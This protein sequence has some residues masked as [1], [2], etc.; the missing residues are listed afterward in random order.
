MITHFLSAIDLFRAQKLRFLL[1]VSGIV[2]GVGSLVL[3][4]SLLTTGAR[5]LEAQS[6][7]ASGDDVVTVQND[8]HRMQND[9]NAQRLRATDKDALDRSALLDG[10]TISANYGMRRGVNAQFKGKEFSPFLL[11]A[12]PAI[13]D[14]NRLVVAKGRGFSTDEFASV[15][16]VVIVGGDVQDGKVEP[17]DTIRIGGAPYTVVGVLASKAEMGPGGV[18]SWNQ[19]LIVPDRMFNLDFNPSKRPQSVVVRVKPPLAYTGAVKDYALAVRGVINTILLREHDGAR[20]SCRS[21]A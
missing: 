21:A 14:V 3:L 5:V 6:F 10:E 8:W 15:R 2:V 9:P 16:R 19:R 18:W 7:E 11:G 20:S 4:A 1:T 12:S 13:F 17:G